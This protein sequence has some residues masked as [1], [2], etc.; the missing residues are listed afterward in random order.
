MEPANGDYVPPI[1]GEDRLNDP[2]SDVDGAGNDAFG[3]RTVSVRSGVSEGGLVPHL[4][5]PD[6]P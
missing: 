4:S 5:R 1:L 6:F 2:A 3:F